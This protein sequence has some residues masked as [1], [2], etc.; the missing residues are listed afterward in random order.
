MK[1]S[2]PIV[3]WAR[4]TPPPAEFP[5]LLWSS[6]GHPNQHEDTISL[7]TF[8]ETNAEVVRSRLL[9][10]LCAAKEVKCS[11]STLEE[12]LGTSEGLSTWWLSF[13]SLKQWGKRQSIP[14]ACRL[15]AIE[16][17]VGREALS[18]IKI[19]S[20]NKALASLIHQTLG[21]SPSLTH[22]LQRLCMRRVIHP[23]RA[24]GSAVRFLIQTRSV[25]PSR[26]SD[27]RAGASGIAFF[28][29][30]SGVDVARQVED[31][32][33]SPYWGIA[34]NMVQEPDWYHIFPRN[35]SHKD[36][37]ETLRSIS[38]LNSTTRSRHSLF[39]EPLLFAECIV[40]LRQYVNQVLVHRRFRRELLHLALHQSRLRLWHVFEQEW[41]DSIIGS[42]AFRHLILLKSTDKMIRRIPRYNKIF[43]LMEN[44]PWELVLTHCVRAHNKGQLIGV[45]HSTIRY[46]DLR[47]FSDRKENAHVVEGS[48][49]PHPD[50]ILV[51]GEAGRQL[52]LQN[53]FPEGSVSVVEAL[54]YM[55]LQGLRSMPGVVQGH[56]LLLGDFLD[57]ANEVLVKIF[58]EAISNLPDS[59]NVKVRSHPICPLS[60]L[61]LGPLSSK[62]SN[63]SLAEL[64]KSASVVVTTA[65]SSSAA[66]S[67]A[68]G[69]PTII[70]LDARS[71]NYSP[72]RQS[73]NVYVVENASDLT[74]LLKNDEAL[75]V[76]PV[77][78]IFC[79]DP[80]YP[81][82]R[83]ELS[84]V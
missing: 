56:I 52:L 11:G 2:P 28:D 44:Q 30:F 20:D 53:E 46:W 61:Q 60:E 83:A 74:R 40:L 18:Q 10:F 48:R 36:L 73:D 59:L 55:Y 69:I 43:Y 45:A 68:L 41:D 25:R 22:R 27:F 80:D 14:I 15:V 12:S 84:T 39:L 77:D 3:V 19:E 24:L 8:I 70:V 66:E 33:I 37:V 9:K 72:F 71:L 38:H 7:P 51:N 21:H 34:P 63:E 31:T 32:Y 17:I 23:L 35:V 75:E 54:R 64:L 47:Y 65:A 57:H 29:Y 49:R 4:E 62:L 16:L 58:R 6:F 78:A 5:V 42:T 50:R 13:P 26:D 81:R 67:A 82:W 79:L 1:S 76:E